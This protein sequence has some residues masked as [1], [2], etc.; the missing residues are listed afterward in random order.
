MKKISEKII[1]AISPLMCLIILLTGCSRGYPEY[2]LNIEDGQQNTDKQ[3]NDTKQ[4]SVE[5]IQDMNGGEA[6]I[7]YSDDGYVSTLTGKYYNEK[8]EDYEQAITSLNG[9]ASLIGLSA[10]SEFFCVYGEQDNAGY[11]YYTFQQKYG[12]LTLQYATLKVIVDPDGYSAGLSCSFTPN[13]GIADEKTF[14]SASQA[15]SI[16]KKQFPDAGYK[17]YTDYTQKSAVTFNSRTV[18]CM[19]VYTSNPNQSVSFDMPFIEHFVTYAGEYLTSVPT[20]SLGTQLSDAYKTD[21]YFKNL[22]P[23]TYSGSVRLHD[24]TTVNITVPTAYNAQDGKYYLADIT[25]KIMVS[26]YAAFNYQGAKLDFITTADNIS[27]DANHLITYYNYIRAYDYYADMK[28]KSIDG[29]ETPILITVNMCTEDGKPDDNACFYGIN[30]GWACFGSSQS[31]SYGEALDVVAHEYT[32]GVTRS[33]MQGTKY[34]NET[35]AINEA[36]SDIMGNIVEMR[37]NATN[38]G[39][40][41]LGEMSGKALR[42][43]SNPNAYNQPEYVGDVY[44]GSNVL[45][46]H[47]YNDNGSV[48]QNNSLLS[49]IAYQ[50]Y[51]NGMSLAEESKLWFTSINLITP[52][53]DY[54]DIHASLLFSAK[55]NGL[56]KYNETITSLF[57]SAGLLGDREKTAYLAEKSGCGRIETSVSEELAKGADYLSIYVINYDG[58]ATYSHAVCPDLKGRISALL[59]AGN[60]AIVYTHVTNEG[61]ANYAYGSS[62]WISGTDGFA[63]VEVKDG[64]TTRLNEIR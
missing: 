58:T 33:A 4:L 46:P 29:F 31:N 8:I 26:D 17:Y 12:G 40:W 3:Y 16:V 32:H 41:L 47:Q 11:T 14:I 9:I 1:T 60:Y 2:R 23:K 15:G 6:V 44:Y 28:I 7:V 24:G 55:I 22:E 62:G 53:S 25:R 57:N 50:L 20:S 42:S 39:A 43:M 5:D 49:H 30:N 37:A 19:V 61:V 45:T 38:D 48:H 35:G 54:D 13:V 51:K 21:D 63:S 36:Y 52:L 34:A 18:E 10:G 27:W 64:A 59:P 56:Q